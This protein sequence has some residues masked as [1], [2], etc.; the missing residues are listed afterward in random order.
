MSFGSGVI[1]QRKRAPLVS[2]NTGLVVPSAL[3]FFVLI[4]A[5]L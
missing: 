4:F 3:L 1:F 2:D 5:G